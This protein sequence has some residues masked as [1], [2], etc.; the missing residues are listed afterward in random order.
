[1]RTKILCAAAALFAVACGSTPPPKELLDARAAYKKA[2]E[3][4]A[5]ETAPAQ[6][7]EAKNALDSANQAFA[8]DADSPDT[9]DKAYLAM[10]KA[11]QAEA[12]ARYKQAQTEKE[13]AQRKAG[14][15]T[16]ES[17]S[18]TRQE[19]EKTKDQLEKEK[20][21]RAEA[22]KRAAQ[23][24]ADLQKIASVKQE[25]R[26]IVITLSGGVLFASNQSTLLPAAMIK[27]NEVAE[28]LVKNNPDSKIVVEGHTDSQGKADYNRDL[29]QKRADAV[30][31]YL[32][33]RGIAADRIKAVG[34]GSERPVAD[35]NSAE[36]RANNRRVEIVVEPGK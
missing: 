17:L 25:T 31:D 34:Y 14:I 4:P 26:G 6:L 29:S 19:L 9:K 2:A 23:A 18:K 33:S 21:A 24:M 20:Q 27:L 1:M 16:A 36:G 28:A 11:E 13:E 30:R 5:K 15:L 32:I 10:R 35:N 3:G 22:E 12:Y 8:D 7:H